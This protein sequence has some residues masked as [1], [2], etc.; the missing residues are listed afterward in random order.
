MRFVS[1]A[2]NFED[3]MLWRALRTVEGGFYID[4]GAQDPIVDSV[5]Y[6]FYL[7]GWRG[8]HVEP[9]VQYAEKLRTARPDEVVEQLLISD[10]GQPTEFFVI[11]D[12]GL[13]TANQSIAAQHAESG[14][15]MSTSVVSSASLDDLFDKHQVPNVHWLKVDVEGL[16]ADVISSWKHSTVRPWILVI[17]STVPMTRQ[18]NHEGWDGLVLEKGYK[19]VYFDGLNRFYLHSDHLDLEHFFDTPPNIF[20]DVVL[21]GIASNSLCTVFKEREWAQ[22]SVEERLQSEISAQSASII[23]LENELAETV[24]RLNAQT[25]VN[26]LLE[27]REI[28]LVSEISWLTK[29]LNN[30]H[31]ALHNILSSRLWKAIYPIRFVIDRWPSNQIAR[32]HPRRVRNSMIRRTKMSTLRAIALVGKF[33]K[34]KAFGVLALKKSGAYESI[35]TRYVA[36]LTRSKEQLVSPFEFSDLGPRASYI[37]A[38]LLSRKQLKS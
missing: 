27:E 28:A 31:Q 36:H 38:D 21:G 35:K 29:S 34:I 33:P 4:I 13:S 25:A 22:R 30:T 14:F 3:V 7:Q 18:Q 9:S 17:E 24:K 10:S 12:T 20:D 1:Y 37:Y 26:Q 32:L 11:A 5:S 23:T 19:F 8:L 2:Q 16:E 15:A 6:G